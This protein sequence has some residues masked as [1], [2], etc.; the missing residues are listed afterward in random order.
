[1]TAVQLDQ[2]LHDRQAETEARTCRWSRVGL[3][4]ALEQMRQKVG[5]DADA[6]VAHDEL[7]ARAGTSQRDLDEAIAWRNFTAFVRSR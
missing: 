7:G 5:A 6:R 4:E 2:L 1:V 3:P